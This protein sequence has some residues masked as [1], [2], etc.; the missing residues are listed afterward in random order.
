MED[1]RQVAQFVAAF[2]SSI[3][4]G[5]AVYINL[6]EHPARMACGTLV[7]AAEFAPSYK[8]AALMQASLAALGFVASIA[9]WLTGASVWWLAAGILLGSVIPF[10]FLFIMPTN[11]ELLDPSLDKGSDRA[12]QLLTRWGHLHAVRSVL[13]T[14]ALLIFLSCLF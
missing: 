9:A 8:R 14:I 10:T 2:C 12:N 11:K 1:I 13:A 7:A 5:A 3:F 6:V 4:T